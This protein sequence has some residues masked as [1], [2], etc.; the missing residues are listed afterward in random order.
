MRPE[1]MERLRMRG[2][3]RTN[4]LELPEH[5]RGEDVESRPVGEEQ[6][7]DV[8]PADVRRSSQGGLPVSAAPV[9]AGVR[10]RGVDVES[11]AN[12]AEVAVGV[13][14]ELAHDAVESGR[15]LPGM[16]R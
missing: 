10:E 8:A 7:G 1:D 13:G 11:F 15:G 12:R 6:L 16:I 4:D 5:R 14:D 9:P 2:Q 3:H